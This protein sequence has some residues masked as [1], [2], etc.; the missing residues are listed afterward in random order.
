MAEVPKS[1]GSCE[2]GENN[3]CF[4]TGR[5]A[6][7]DILSRPAIANAIGRVPPLAKSA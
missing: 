5:F 3:G 2:L 1:T 7:L 6:S 4:R